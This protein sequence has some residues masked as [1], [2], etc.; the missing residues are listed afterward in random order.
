MNKKLI[1]CSTLVLG[2]TIIGGCQKKDVKDIEADDKPAITETVEN[3][4]NKEDDIIK[5]ESETIDFSKIE[6]K[7][8]ETERDEKL[9]ETIID[10]LDYDKNEDG[11]ITYFYNYIDLNED[12]KEEIFVYLLGDPVS[13]SGGSTALIIE[14][15][16]YRVISKFTLVQ[17]PIIIS[18]EKTNGWNNIIMSVSGGGADPFYAKLEFNGEG[19]PS[20]PSM[21]SKVEEGSVIAGTAIISNTASRD[22]GIKIK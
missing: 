9:E 13:G 10:Y 15:E 14:K 2:L 7:S 3:D 1:L 19:Y 8:S 6:Y 18:E 16:D 5:F 21:A 11:E 20:N 22:S 4:N 12:E 17:N